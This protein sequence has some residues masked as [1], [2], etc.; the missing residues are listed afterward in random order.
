MFFFVGSLCNSSQ[1]VALVSYRDEGIVPPE[2]GR[3]GKKV[4]FFSSIHECVYWYN[5]IK[6]HGAFDISKLKITVNMF[7]ARMPQREMLMV[8]SLLLRKVDDFVIKILY[9]PS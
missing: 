1:I 2:K 6:L 7:Y 9:M 4:R 3:I 5:T 8:P